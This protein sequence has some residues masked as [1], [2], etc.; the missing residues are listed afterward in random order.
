MGDKVLRDNRDVLYSHQYHES[1]GI[2]RKV[3]PVKTGY[4]F[5]RLLMPCNDGDLRGIFPVGK[6]DTDSAG[7]REG[8]GDTRNEFYRDVVLPQHFQFLA[9][10]AEE[11]RITA[12]EPD[13]PF[14]FLCFL[15]HEGFY[16]LL[17][18]GMCSAELSAIDLLSFFR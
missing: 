12:F 15:D 3:L 4:W 9:P 7:D 18:K 16:G 8:A 1:P 10:S 14:S 11:K 6:G 2:F 5:S 17:L 13:H